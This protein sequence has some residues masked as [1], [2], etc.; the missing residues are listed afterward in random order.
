MAANILTGSRSRHWRA[1]LRLAIVN[2][3]RGERVGRA[4]LNCIK[5]AF[6]NRSATQSQT[7]YHGQTRITAV[8]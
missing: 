8:D 2:W 5:T 4:E 7:L 3:S 1:R 6:V